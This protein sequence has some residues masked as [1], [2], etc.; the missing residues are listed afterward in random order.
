M[1]QEFVFLTVAL[2]YLLGVGAWV[3]T[4]NDPQ[5]GPFVPRITLGMF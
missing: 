3:Q 1:L 2:D 5:P 4:L